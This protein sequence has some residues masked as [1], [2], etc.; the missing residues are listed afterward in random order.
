VEAVRAAS[1]PAVL[2]SKKR[3]DDGM[4]FSY[5]ISE[6]EYL[7]ATK[8]KLKSD[9]RLG[10]IAKNIMFWVFII[11][12]LM[13][14]FGIVQ[15]SHQQPTIPDEAAI[16]TTPPA[17]AAS[18]IISNLVPIIVAVGV[19]AFVIFKRVPMRLRRVYRNDPLMQGQFTLN[20][21]PESISIQSTAGTSSSTGWNIYDYWR[22]G[23]D[24]IL[25]VLH[26]G[27]AFP[28]SL[29]NLSEAQR[30]E[31]RGILATALP[32]K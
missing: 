6:A 13:L 23:K 22:E 16:Q 18:S 20:I 8:L 25:M 32:K 10:R 21:T 7:S 15:K 3:Q 9:L 17:Q 2:P 30:V 27:V 12:C 1:A 11:I 26:S 24:V 29:A 4:E 28:I 5:R 31:L 14:V 19:V